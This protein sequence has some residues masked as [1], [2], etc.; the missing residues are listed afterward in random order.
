LLQRLTA[1]YMLLF[2]LLLLGHFLIDPPRSHAD[3]REW[4]LSPG[5]STG[6]TLFFAALFLHTW[7]GVR[8]VILDYL[9]PVGLRLGALA[10]LGC[11]LLAMSVW[12]VR[13]LFNAGP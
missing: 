3:W 1:V 2:L 10:V 5:P 12:A 8:D 11:G 4:V 13:L 6:A 7:V 9:H